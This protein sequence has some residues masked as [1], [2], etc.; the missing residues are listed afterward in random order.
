MLLRPVQQLLGNQVFKHQR[1]R[2][3]RERNLRMLL[4]Q[5]DK[6]VDILKEVG[7][8]DSLVVGPAGRPQDP[9]L[10]RLCRQ[11][12]VQSPISKYPAQNV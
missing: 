3:D 12:P 1:V 5:F 11:R 6:P 4:R 8:A 7:S 9:V 2:P 10:S